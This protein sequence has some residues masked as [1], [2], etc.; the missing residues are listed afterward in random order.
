MYIKSE[1]NNKG[2]LCVKELDC[3]IGYVEF[4]EIEKGFVFIYELKDK[5]IDEEKFLMVE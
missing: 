2:E 1:C 3:V 4:N 5:V